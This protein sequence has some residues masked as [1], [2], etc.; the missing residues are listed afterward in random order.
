MLYT[1]ARSCISAL[2]LRQDHAIPPLVHSSSVRENTGT[3]HLPEILY[4]GNFA[5][6]VL[7][8]VNGVFGRISRCQV[9]LRELFE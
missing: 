3:F 4:C 7:D 1:L 6:P 2:T 8:F 9:V 5:Q